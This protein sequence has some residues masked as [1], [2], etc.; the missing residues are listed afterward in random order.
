MSTFTGSEVL[1]NQVI[2][3]TRTTALS[4][5]ASGIAHELN[6]PLGAI[7]TFSQAGMRMLDRPE[8]M[9]SGALDVFRQINQQALDAGE[10]IRRIRRLFDQEDAEPTRCH[11]E[12]LIAEIE[13][14][15]RLLLD[16][17]NGELHVDALQASP[18]IQVDRAKIQ[19]VLFA[20]VQ[21]G[22][23][24]GAADGAVPP[25]V[26]VSTTSDRYGV[27]TSV[28][29]SGPGVPRGGKASTVQAVLYDQSA[30]YR[31]WPRIGTRDSGSARR[32]HWI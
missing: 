4:E 17:F 21:N 2:E 13:P 19:H 22:L 27:E 31:A 23:E 25:L 9:V 6:Q 20:L 16:R 5:M 3:I 26:R 1:L 15:L 7:A 8:P 24:G 30:R 18:A 10:G 12:E 29:D 11:M 32:L 28:I 14:V